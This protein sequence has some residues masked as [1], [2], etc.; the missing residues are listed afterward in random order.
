MNAGSYVGRIGGLAVALGVGAAVFTG[1]GV[2]YAEPTGSESSSGSDTS[3]SGADNTSGTGTD[4]KDATDTSNSNESSTGSDSSDDSTSE[5]DES[6]PVEDTPKK[7]RRWAD[8]FGG[9]KG[10]ATPDPDTTEP[11]TSPDAD[12]ETPPQ[13]SGDTTDADKQPR[14][15]RH[16]LFS[17]LT[18][19]P[20]PSAADTASDTS[21]D[22]N[23]KGVTDTKENTTSL[24]TVRVDEPQ[25]ATIQSAVSTTE[26]TPETTTTA[27]TTESAETTTASVDGPIVTMIRNILDAFSGNSPSAPAVNSPFAWLV[28]AASR[29]ELGTAATETQDPTMVW[30]GYN[31]VPVGQPTISQFYGEYTM[32]PAFPGIVQGQQDFDLVDPDSGETMATVHGLV[33]INNDL[34]AG[35]RLLQF[36]VTEVTYMDP[37]VEIG[38]DKFDIPAPGSVFASVSNGRVGTSY[39]ALDNPGGIDVV[40]YKWMTSRLSFNLNPDPFNLDFS[41]ADFLFDNEGVNRPIYTKDGHYI[42]PIADSVVWT[43]YAGYQPLFN[44]IQGT[45]TF[46]LYDEETEELIGTFE[47]VVTV[48]SD[49]WGTTSEAIL[50]TDAEGDVGTDAGQIPPVGTIYN[51]I[52]WTADPSEYLLYYAKPAEQPNANVVKTLLVDVNRRGVEQVSEIKLNFDAAA[53]PVRESLDVPGFNGSGY[54]FVPTS[55]KV[56]SGV[57]GLPPREAIVQGYQQFDVFDSNGKYLGNVDADVSTQWDLA[58]NS[59]EAILVIDVNDVADDFEEHR[60]G[61]G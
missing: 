35:N 33:T 36:V 12:G 34:G 20:T 39:S 31:V 53:P 19:E 5:S 4:S 46:G 27:V 52:Y 16:R 55:E 38:I 21:T 42:E 17:R 49:F 7:K 26:E 59:S 11:E 2:A 37:D 61:Q 50:V 58:G 23:T 51:I 10:A 1:T 15:G 3:S 22:T 30:N 44:A 18:D 8:L 13:S 54:S 40:T 25:S 57:N 14:P 41:S 60:H 28:A 29:R 48:T 24:T 9:D 6:D 43:G 45:G 32:V 47:G 56:Y